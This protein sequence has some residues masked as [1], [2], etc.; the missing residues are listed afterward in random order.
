MSRLNEP[1]RLAAPDGRV[2]EVD[3]VTGRRYKATGG[4]MYT[5]HPTDAA[6]F[7]REGAFVPTVGGVSTRGGYQCP[8]CG[9][10]AYLRACGRCGARCE[11]TDERRARLVELVTESH[12][13]ECRTRMVD[14]DG[15]VEAAS[16]AGRPRLNAP[17]MT[18][19]QD[20]APMARSILFGEGTP[21]IKIIEEPTDIPAGLVDNLLRR[22][23]AERA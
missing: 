12:W 9:F 18:R 1:V 20:W 22:N 8:E 4:G 10:M 5:M 13:A 2:A 3:G 6:A 16:P 11:T 21:S 7:R 15:V 23:R 14:D 19:P 17:I